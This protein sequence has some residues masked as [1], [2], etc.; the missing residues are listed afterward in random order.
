MMAVQ[1][2]DL[3]KSTDAALL[4][5]MERCSPTTQDVS[6]V[7]VCAPKQ[8]RL[9]PYDETTVAVRFSPILKR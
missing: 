8:G 6:Q 9:G 7:M 3:Q 1:G 5:K 4:E 2:T